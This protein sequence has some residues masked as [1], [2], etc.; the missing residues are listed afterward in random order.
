MPIC[1]AVESLLAFHEG[2][3]LPIRA[4]HASFAPG[5]MFAGRYRVVTRIGR[6]GMG[7][8]WRADD[9]VL[10]TPVALKLILRR[11]PWPRSF[12]QRGTAGASRSPIPPSVAS[13]TSANQASG[14]SYSMEFVSGEDL[15]S[16]IRRV[17]LPSDRVTDI[18]CQLCGGS[19]AAHAQKVLR[20]LKPANILS[21]M[22]AWCALRISALR[23]CGPTPAFT[24]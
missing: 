18:A 6:G 20:D 1:G 11:A 12:P 17:D 7:D 14:F 24:C 22:R 2:P 19:A 8:V 5:E 3:A 21:T 15:A 13:S 16:L 4:R 10:N 23:F 9:T